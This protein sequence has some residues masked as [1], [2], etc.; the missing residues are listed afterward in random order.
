MFDKVIGHDIP[1]KILTN[2]IDKNKISHAY[3]FVGPIGVGKCKLAEEFTKMLLNLEDLKVAIDYKKIEKIEGKKNILVEQIR[4]ELVE[5]VYTHPAA[6]DYK[7]Y[8]ID[9]AEYLNEEAQNSLLKTLE[10]PP[11]YV[12]IILITQNMQSFLPT[13]ISRVKQIKFSKLSDKEINEYCGL[14]N[15]ENNFNDN[16]LSYIDGSVGKMLKLTQE[17]EYNLFKQT[18]EIVEN[19]KKKNELQVLR[20]LEKITFKNTDALDYLQYLLYL[21]NLYDEL[22]LVEEARNKMKYNAN[23]D[24][25]KTVLAINTCR[26]EK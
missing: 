12:C 21:N 15:I 8:I 4:K 13:I 11:E 6:S 22:F 17:E 5:D 2:D 24:I 16:M 25:L 20:L 3:A 9:D 14:N 1:K 23:E 19:I 26:K 10:E 7:V 18:E